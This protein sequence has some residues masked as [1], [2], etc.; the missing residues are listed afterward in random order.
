[1]RCKN[2]GWPNKPNEK[3]CVKCH[4][5]LEADNEEVY[6]ESG[7][8]NSFAGEQQLNKTVME[9]EI[10]PD[11]VVLCLDMHLVPCVV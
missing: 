8:G 9:Q 4:A 11:G 3:V 5:P 2:C 7:R 6:N 1:M 10:F